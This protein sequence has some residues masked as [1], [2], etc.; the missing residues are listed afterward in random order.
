MVRDAAQNDSN[1]SAKVAL[2]AI[3]RSMNA[4]GALQSCLPEKKDSTAPLM[5]V[6][7]R[8]RD[9]IETVLPQARDFLRPGFDEVLSDFVS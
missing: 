8:L 7:E 5:V 2:I 9:G 1:G 6:L 3:D 4:W